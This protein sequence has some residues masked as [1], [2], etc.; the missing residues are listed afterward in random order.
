MSP[1]MR[2]PPRTLVLIFMVISIG[3]DVISNREPRDR[4]E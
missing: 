1:Q 4:F 2:L 3:C